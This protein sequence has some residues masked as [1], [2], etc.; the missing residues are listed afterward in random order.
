MAGED[1]VSLTANGK[2]FNLNLKSMHEIRYIEK[3]PLFGDDNSPS[4]IQD[5]LKI[6]QIFLYSSLFFIHFREENGT[7]RPIQRKLTSQLQPECDASESEEKLAK[8]N[9]HLELTANVTKELLPILLEVYS[10]S[11][12]PGVRHSCIQAFLR[13][14]YHS[15]QELLVQ[16]CQI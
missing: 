16:V 15:D 12:G 9:K 5:V 2:A 11:A 10:T 13:M 1:E 7:A 6:G 14:V 4:F 8:R 3:I